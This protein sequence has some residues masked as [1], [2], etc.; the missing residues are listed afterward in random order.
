MINNI[1]WIRHGQS[2]ANTHKYLHSIYL[3][4]PLTEIGQAEILNV[5]VTLKN[6]N[7]DLI[8]CSPL[9]RSIESGM[10]IKNYLHVHSGLDPILVTWNN[11]S[12]KGFG[13]DNISINNIISC[14]QPKTLKDSLSSGSNF[15]TFNNEL[16]K[17][18]KKYKNIVIVGHEKIN[19]IY[20]KKLTN[21][22]I[23]PMKNG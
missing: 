13:L 15:D 12:E 20:I 11:I 18:I 9:I 3:D 6:K 2:V 5:A 10:I 8:I 17:I 23:M 14:I 4:P 22:S 19:S 21:Q 16:N 7:I 1:Y